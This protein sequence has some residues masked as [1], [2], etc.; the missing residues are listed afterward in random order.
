[1]KCRFASSLA[2]A[3]VLVAEPG[4]AQSF[5]TPAE[6]VVIGQGYDFASAILGDER[7]INVSLPVGYDSEEAA[8]ERYPVL[9]VLD[10][11]DGWQDFGH[12]STMV[13][14]GG[15][16]GANAPMIVVG[17]RSEDRRAEFTTPTS[18]PKE[19]EDFPTSGKAADFRRFLVEE[20]QPAIDAAYRTNGTKGVIG[21]SLAG[22]FITDLFLNH[23]TSFT[24]YIAVDPSLWWNRGQLSHRAGE[25][26]SASKTPN[27]HFWMSMAD[28]GGEMQAGADRVVEALR[29]EGPDHVEWRYRAF[30]DE[31]HATI[32]HPAATEAVRYMFPAPEAGAE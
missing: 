1:M 9:F 13:Q 2:L 28:E 19:L 22:L 4:S 32:Y 18:D 24:H 14:Q 16:W 15:T 8:A 27:Q 10:G 12:I 5:E 29:R 25:L 23:P 20:L 11:G 7:R 30:P 21:E 17:I 6:A 3:F 31:S 26:L